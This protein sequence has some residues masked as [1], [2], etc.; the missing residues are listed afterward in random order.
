MR[1]GFSPCCQLRKPKLRDQ[2]LAQD[3]RL[4]NHS[5]FIFNSVLFISF[6]FHCGHAACRILVP[7]PGIKHW[8]YRVLT[9]L[10]LG[11]AGMSLSPSFYFCFF[12][13]KVIGHM[14]GDMFSSVQLLSCVWLCH[15]M[16]CSTPGLPVQ[17]QLL[18]PT[19]THVHWVG[20]AIQPL[21]PLPSLSPSTFNLSQQQGLL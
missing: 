17:H 19:Q 8:K 21:H 18:E 15:S 5:S 20:D 3:T 13:S 10:T 2:G 12:L 4:V 9:I 14:L 6:L 7:P 16:D 11:G 1:W